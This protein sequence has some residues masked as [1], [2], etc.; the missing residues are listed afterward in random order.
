MDFVFYY[1]RLQ[2]PFSL[3]FLLKS[4]GVSFTIKSNPSAICLKGEVTRLTCFKG[5]SE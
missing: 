1:F 3:A 2:N 5:L 4:T